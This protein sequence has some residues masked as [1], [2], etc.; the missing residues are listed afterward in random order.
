M[1]DF[2]LTVF[3]TLF[4]VLTFVFAAVAYH[5]QTESGWPED[6][7]ESPLGAVCGALATGSLGGFVALMFC[8]TLIQH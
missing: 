8:L 1:S 2:Y 4:G 7:L 5:V 6:V 3:A